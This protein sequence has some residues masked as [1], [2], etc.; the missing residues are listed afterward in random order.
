[1]ILLA[2]IILRTNNTVA[3]WNEPT[4]NCPAGIA[5]EI[6]VEICQIF[7][8][9]SIRPSSSGPVGAVPMKM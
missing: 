2:F 9:F 1:V 5:G 3:N 7:I 6:T 4:K 8:G